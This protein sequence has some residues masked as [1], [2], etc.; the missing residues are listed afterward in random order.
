MFPR[1]AIEKS[2]GSQ[3]SGTSIRVV[4]DSGVPIHARRVLAADL[5]LTLIQCC[6]DV[7][8]VVGLAQELA[9][10]VLVIEQARSADLN[11]RTVFE[12]F[13]K[14]IRTLVLSSNSGDDCITSLLESGHSGVLYLPAKPQTIRKALRVVASGEIWAARRLLSDFIRQRT[15]FA[16]GHLLTQREADILKLIKKGHRNKEIAEHLF[17]THDT[18]RWHERRLYS[19]LGVQGR[20]DLLKHG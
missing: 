5:R 11:P 18:V 2:D 19:K 8:E 3:R 12:L 10:C 7:K 1:A 15:L 4:V 20:T 9:P 16:S 13:K 14:G 17:V 6:G